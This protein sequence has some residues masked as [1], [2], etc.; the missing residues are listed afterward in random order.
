MMVLLRLRL[1][2]FLR[3]RQR[4]RLVLLLRPRLK[5]LRSGSCKLTL[6]NVGKMV[7]RG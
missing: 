4:L 5:W 3:L 2:L 6:S 1:K 7:K